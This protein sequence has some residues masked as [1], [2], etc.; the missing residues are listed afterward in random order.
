MC[1]MINVHN[2]MFCIGNSISCG[3]NDKNQYRMKPAGSEVSVSFDR[4]SKTQTV[5]VLTY[6]LLSSDLASVFPPRT[7]FS[8]I[9]TRTQNGKQ[10]CFLPEGYNG[11]RNLSSSWRVWWKPEP[12]F[13]LRGRMK[14]RSHCLPEGYDRTE[15]LSSSWRRQVPSS[16]R[17]WWNTEP[18]FWEH[19]NLSSSWKVGWIMEFVWWNTA[20]FRTFSWCF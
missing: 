2:F 5:Q 7:S 20:C 17:V 13:F 6:S 10:T 14:Q 16:W 8:S 12:I 3:Q 15:N 4:L 1:K 19:W 11:T 9:F 18:V